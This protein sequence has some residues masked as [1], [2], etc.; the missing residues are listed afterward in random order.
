VTFD[1]AAVLDISGR[2]GV[3]VFARR[4]I[5]GMIKT[6]KIKNSTKNIIEHEWSFLWV[7]IMEILAILVWIATLFSILFDKTYAYYSSDFEKN[8]NVHSQLSYYAYESNY[9]VVSLAATMHAP[10]GKFPSIPANTNFSRPNLHVISELPDWAEM[11]YILNSSICDR[12]GDTGTADAHDT[13][14]E[15]RYSIMNG[16]EYKT[17]SMGM[18]QHPGFALLGIF[19]LLSDHVKKG[20][21]Y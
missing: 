7:V 9:T 1:L 12:F 4:I 16:G 14:C 3:F 10:A 20:K 5:H 21:A 18:L 15:F 17:V 11:L 6:R 13:E 19:S 2:D 8:D